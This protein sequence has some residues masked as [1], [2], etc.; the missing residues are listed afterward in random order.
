MSKEF[1]Q[2]FK[3]LVVGCWNTFFGVSLYTIVILIFGEAHYL[4]LGFLCNIVAITQSF[5]SHKLLVFKTKGNIL[6]EY[7][8]IYVTYSF[9]MLFGLIAMYI[10]V[11]LMHIG[12]IYANLILT[13]FS[14]VLNF[15][16][17]KNF[18]FKR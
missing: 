9:S 10:L 17:H 13:C 4:I 16:L 2:L 3:Y 14:V 5:F 15:F 12:A 6:K 8:R 18:T 11:D 1:V 7:L